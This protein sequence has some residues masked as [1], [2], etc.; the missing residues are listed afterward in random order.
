MSAIVAWW[1]KLGLQTRLQILIQGSLIVFLVAGQQWITV[2]FESQLLAAA[3]ERAV[4]IADGLVN[5]LNVLMIIKGA[6]DKEVIFDRAARGEFVHKMAQSEG[7]LDMRVIRGAAIDEEF[8]EGLPDAYARDDMDRRVMAGGGP[9]WRLDLESEPPSLRSVIPYVAKKNFRGINCLGCHAVDEGATV[10]AASVT[11]DVGAD[12]RAIHTVTTW[13][14]VGLAVLQVILFFILRAIV[15]RLLRLLGGEPRDVVDVMRQIAKGNLSG[16]IETRAGDESSLLA[17]TK[18]MQTALRNLVTDLKSS[19]DAV[20]GSSRKLDSEARSVAERSTQQA[21]SSASMAATIEELTTSI[22][23]MA[24]SAATSSGLANKAGEVSSKGAQNIQETAGEVSSV[25][26]VV[27]RASTSVSTLMQASDK[28]SEVVKVIKEIADQTNLLALNAAIEAA[29]AGEQGRGF[30]VVADEVRKLAERTAKSTHQIA[31]MITSI[32][33]GT[34]LAVNGIEAGAQRSHA[35]AARME[36][37]A[38]SMSEIALGTEQLVAQIGEIS[39]ALQ[40][41][42]AGSER[43]AHNVE[44][45]VRM[46]DDNTASVTSVADAAHA[47]NSMAR[48]LEEQIQHFHI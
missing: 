5:G 4:A 36:Q 8:D 12:L 26:D 45:I 24:E 16:R 33:D 2:K 29:R 17:H 3:R 23:H 41:Q 25:A 48:K 37:A 42:R 13:M 47:L 32:Q 27:N 10:G 20:L 21:D 44:T 38:A 31:E 28:I 34:K 7:T 40:E 46:T 43:I 19:V 18:Q 14:W 39:N 22:A 30:A 6:N 11:I 15:G 9:E 1:G 35:S